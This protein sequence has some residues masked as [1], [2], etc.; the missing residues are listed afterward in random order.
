[1]YITS[2]KTEKLIHK[3]FLT[4]KLSNLINK[5]NLKHIQFTIIRKLIKSILITFISI[6]M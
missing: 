2:Y 6:P 1:M 3:T 4:I 5:T